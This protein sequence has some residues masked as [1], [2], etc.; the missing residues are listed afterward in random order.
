MIGTY[1][2]KKITVMLSVVLVLAATLLGGCSS[3]N[4]ATTYFEIPTFSSNGHLLMV[5]EIPAGTNK[6]LEYSYEKNMFLMERKDGKERVINFL[7]YPGNYGFIP[8]TL[9]DRAR[10][11]DGDA[12]DI[13]LISEHIP[14]GTVIEVEPIGVIVL[15]D[16]GENDTKIIAIPAE[17]SLRVLDVNSVNQFSDDYAPIKELI[18]LWFLNYKGEGIMKF[19]R[20]GDPR[21]AKEII[22]TWAVDKQ[23]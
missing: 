21:S 11:G 16:N 10:G 23:T 7:P 2:C 14:T 18:K 15:S 3:G 20:W 13:L 1:G 17:E 19:E 12:L 4:L 8:S 5:V 6:K 9:M 22:R